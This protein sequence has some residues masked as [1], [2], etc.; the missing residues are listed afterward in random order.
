MKVMY[1]RVRLEDTKDGD[2]ISLRLPR[3]E[4]AQILDTH[5]KM[6]RERTK[7]GGI[8]VPLGVRQETDQKADKNF[9]CA[10]PSWLLRNA[11]VT[12]FHRNYPPRGS[13][14][15]CAQVLP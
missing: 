1:L 10:D 14:S 9:D 11:K 6:R 13:I 3:P 7:D 12:R 8:L 2:V 4:K 15:L 5:L